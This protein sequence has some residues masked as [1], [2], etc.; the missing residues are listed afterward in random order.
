[1]DNF[2]DFVPVYEAGKTID[3]FREIN[4]ILQDIR[5]VGS[6]TKWRE[7]RSQEAFLNK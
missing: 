2:D 3:Q 4:Q 6:F 1:L 7:N 5:G